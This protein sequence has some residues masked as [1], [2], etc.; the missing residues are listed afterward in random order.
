MSTFSRTPHI[1]LRSLLDAHEQRMAAAAPASSYPPTQREIPPA[2]SVP[3][4]RYD[5]E[6]ATAMAR[7]S[8]GLGFTL[9][10]SPYEGLSGRESKLMSE[11]RAAVCEA[12][13]RLGHRYVNDLKHIL[14]DFAARH[15]SEAAAQ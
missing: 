9:Q 12:H 4:M 15:E 2:R 7:Q 10:T 11:A 6:H 8:R 13:E 3:E 14:A 5:L 1:T